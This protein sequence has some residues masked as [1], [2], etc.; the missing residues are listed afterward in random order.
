MKSRIIVLLLVCFGL[1]QAQEITFYYPVGVAGPLARV[2]EQYVAE[3]EQAH[4]GISVTPIFGGNYQENQARVITSLRAGNPPDTA[5]LLATQYW[6]MKEHG[7]RAFDDLIADDPEGQALVDDVFPA[8]MADS[9]REGMVW[10]IP[11]QRSTPVMYYNKDAFRE[12]GLDPDL[13]PTTWEELVEYGQQIVENTDYWGIMIP[14]EPIGNWLLEALVVQSGG[15]LHE[16]QDG[17]TVYLDAPAT[18]E[19][20]QFLY[21]LGQTHRVSPEGIIRWGTLPNDF[22]AGV[23]AMMYHSTGSLTFVRTN[24]DFEFGTAFHAANERF[25]VSTGG[26]NFYM[27]EGQDD[28]KRAATWTFI[29]WMTS[30]EMTARWSI[31]SGYVATRQSSWDLPLMQAYVQ[32]V[33]QAIAGRD[34]L[35]Y[36]APEFSVFN[37]QQA[38]DVVDR[39]I[40]QVVVGAASVEDASARAQQQLETEVLAPYCR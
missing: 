24:A 26:G 35:Q 39:M 22:V 40:A 32:E 20:L 3:F 5:I 15:A 28:A 17:C 33:P 11:F 31:D 1:G 7:I 30:P 13:P 4:P 19:A 18:H 37:Q 27:F 34:Q 2:I 36:A 21:D 9:I 14:H 12:A 10:S 23:T 6:T 25:G 29:K 8:F 38:V 16:T